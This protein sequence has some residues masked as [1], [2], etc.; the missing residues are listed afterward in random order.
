MSAGAY[1]EAIVQTL[2]ERAGLRVLTRSVNASGR[3]FPVDC[4]YCNDSKGHGGFKKVTGSYHCFKCK[5]SMSLW[6]VVKAFIGKDAAIA[7]YIEVGIFQPARLKTANVPPD[8]VIDT[9]LKEI[10]EAT[11]A[12]RYGVVKTE[13]PTPVAAPPPPKNVTYFPWESMVPVSASTTAVGYLVGE[14]GIPYSSLFFMGSNFPFYW[15]NGPVVDRERDWRFSDRIVIPV[16][17]N[18]ELHSWTGRSILENPK[19]RYL[20]PRQEDTLTVCQHT[21]YPYD[22]L[23]KVKGDVLLI[24]EGVFDSLP[25]NLTSR[26]TGVYAVSVFT[27]NV[28]P[29]QVRWLL[30]IVKNFTAVVI[31][32]GRASCRERV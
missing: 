23:C 12:L 13:K 28:T 18:G 17:I 29:G 24:V 8:E 22:F 20:T 25:V 5:T 27:N 1:T 21:V 6:D 16:L 9:I 19:R 14:R 4:P 3:V 26:T 30:D 2:I 10:E 11:L 31:E 7:A 32:I 15:F